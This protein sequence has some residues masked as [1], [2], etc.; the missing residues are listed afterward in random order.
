M[1]RRKERLRDRWYGLHGEGA[2]GKNAQV[3]TE[4]QQ[5][6]HSVKTQKRSSPRREIEENHRI[7]GEATLF[8]KFRLII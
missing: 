6:L 5:T 7:T 4:S 3:S 2:A 1:V 8:L